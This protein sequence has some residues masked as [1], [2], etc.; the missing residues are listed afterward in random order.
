ME[1]FL[2][3]L[4]SQLKQNVFFS[5]S[6]SLALLSC[7][8]GRP[9]YEY[10]DFKVIVCLFELMIFVKAIEKYGIIDYLSAKIMSLCRNQ[11]RLVQAI[12]VVSFFVSMFITNDIAIFTLIPI[13]IV[14]S[15]NVHYP[16]TFS[17]VLVTVA[18]NLGSSITPIGNPQNLF[19]YSFYRMNFF[20]FFSMALPLFLLSL[21]VIIAFTFF[22]EPL[23][24][25]LYLQKKK[26][27]AN[28]RLILL[29]ILT[30]AAVILI[31]TGQISDLIT[32]PLII[33]AVFLLDKSLLAKVD[34]HLLL[35]FI[36][37]FI[38]IGDV[39]HTYLFD[40][41]LPNFTRTSVQTYIASLTLSQFISNVPC[42]VA[43][44]SMTQHVRE[45]YYG[46]NVGG[47]GTPMASFANIIAFTLFTQQKNHKNI[48]FIR[49]YS[50]INGVCLLFLGVIFFF[51]I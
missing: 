40:E 27:A 6:L 28:G 16:L 25:K 14:I 37:L 7:F 24:I 30:A 17:C 19:M 33:P 1:K 8:F 2:S 20:D 47:L 21:S 23:P 51:I 10:I 38:A 50:I 18:A 34:Y 42:T 49:I 26:P 12:S 36:F 13:L 11:R 22:V 39:S 46:V 48:E 15:K 31:L 9:S 4:Y 5:V 44:A 32:V 35:T 43:L 29:I 41:Y 3:Y 45:L